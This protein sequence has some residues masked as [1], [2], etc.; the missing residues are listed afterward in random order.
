MAEGKRKLDLQPFRVDCSDHIATGE[1]WSDWLDDFE[2][3]LRYFRITEDD[4][5]TDALLIYGGPE[6]KR[7]SRSLEDP[8]KS[9]NYEKLSSK[10]SDYFSPKT[11]THY[12][13]YLFFKMRLN[14]S[15]NTVE[16][17]ARLRDKAL[18]CDFVDTDNRILEHLLQTTSNAEFIRKVIHRKW[19]LQ[20]AL[21]DAQISESTSIQLHAMN[22]QAL[23]IDRISRKNSSSVDTPSKG[24]MKYTKRRIYQD[25]DTTSRNERSDRRLS[26]YR[27]S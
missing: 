10:L 8:E 1:A 16:Y 21:S 9:T 14:S 13:R 25:R 2:R 7:L 22:P 4:D 5:K 12:C 15:E 26:D 19:T 27:D 6:V 11:N 23:G 24:N 18:Q 17:A 20:E 3:Q